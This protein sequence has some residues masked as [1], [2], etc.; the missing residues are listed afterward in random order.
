MS[1]AWK[2]MLQRKAP[3]IRDQSVDN[4][5]K[6]VTSQ[7]IGAGGE[8]LCSRPKPTNSYSAKEEEKVVH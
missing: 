5:S 8:V 1:F 3:E 2:L 6:G 7:R 4:G